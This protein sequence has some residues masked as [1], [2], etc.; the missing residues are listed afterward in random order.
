MILFSILMIILALMVIGL[1][2]L[3]GVGLFAMSP[4]LDIIVCIVII[5]III[6]IL[7]KIFGS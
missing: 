6:K 4:L 2:T 7:M 5:V 1:V 3:I